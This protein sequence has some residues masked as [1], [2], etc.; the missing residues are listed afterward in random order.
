MNKI[1]VIGLG[2][3]G[4]PLALMLSKSYNVNGYDINNKRISDLNKGIDNNRQFSRKEIK[5]FDKIVFSSNH[6]NLMN[7][8]YFIVTVPTPIKNLKP[9]LSILTSACKLIAKYIKKKSIIVFESTVYPGVTED[10]CGKIISKISGFEYKKDFYMAYSPE[11]VNPGDKKRTIEKITKILGASDPKTLQKV[12]MIYSSFLKDKVFTVSNI[13]IAEAAKVIENAQRDINIAFMNEL[14]E[15]FDKADINIFE[16]LRAA[17]TKWNFLNFE[18]GFVG[19]HCIGVD[20]YY[21]AEFAK[22]NKVDPKVILSGR[23]TNERAIKLCMD[24]IIDITYKINNPKVLVLGLTFKEN[25]P[26]IRNSKTIELIQS[27]IDHNIKVSV[28]DPWVHID[29]KDTLM[30]PLIDDLPNKQDFNLIVI[31]VKHKIFYE[32]GYN[33]IKN[34]STNKQ[35]Q[36]MDIKNLFNK[37]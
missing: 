2:Y 13:K 3:V 19:G 10:Y 16:V 22:K 7:S 29:D 4:L 32:I 14:K 30:F 8:N 1:S 5:S 11:R 26:D 18:P 37:K 12:K 33:K 9:D 36:I 28:Y 25:C 27:M 23:K 21:L 17:N 20:P 35:C 24:S 6:K 31:A 15:I 34:I